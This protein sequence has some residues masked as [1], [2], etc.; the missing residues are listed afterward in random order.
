MLALLSRQSLRG[1]VPEFIVPR[2]SS[3]RAALR[4]CS[5]EDFRGVVFDVPHGLAPTLWACLRPCVVNK[6]RRRLH[7]PVGVRADG[8]LAF[9]IF[10]HWLA[11]LPPPVVSVVRRIVARQLWESGL[12][13]RF[14]G[15]QL[16]AV[17]R[18]RARHS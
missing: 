15:S 5:V 2:D 13:V 6:L 18:P 10:H 12:D 3:T 4:A 11:E 8:D 17:V 16:S 7:L 1:T 14:L 9:T